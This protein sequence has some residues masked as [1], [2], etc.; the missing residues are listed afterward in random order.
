MLTDPAP[1]LA[2]R[3]NIT[4]AAMRAEM[5]ARGARKRPADL[6]LAAIVRF[7]E[8]LL[9]LIMDFRAGRLGSVAGAERVFSS[10]PRPPGSSP[11]AS[12]PASAECGTEATRNQ[13]HRSRSF[14]LPRRGPLP[15][16]VGSAAHPS[17]SRCAGPFLSLKGR[18]KHTPRWREVHPPYGRFARCCKK[19]SLPRAGYV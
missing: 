14:S 3:C 12:L 13:S 7:L 2:D 10:L 18:G 16:P 6:L 15:R 19:S 11:A 9:A 1:S 5:A 4:L 8:T 17:P